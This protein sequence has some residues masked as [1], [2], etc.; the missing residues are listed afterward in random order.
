MIS[1]VITRVVNTEKELV[2]KEY[3]CKIIAHDS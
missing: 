3:Y 2:K 1:K